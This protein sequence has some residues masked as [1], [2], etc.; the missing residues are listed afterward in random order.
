MR[1]G[2][3]E[4]VGQDLIKS[5][6]ISRR[7]QPLLRLDPHVQPDAGFPQ[8]RAEADQHV[9]RRL[10]GLEPL[11]QLARL[12]GGD[13][14]EAAHELLGA[15]Q[16][17]QQDGRRL[18]AFGQEPLELGPLHLPGGVQLPQ[19]LGALGE[20]ARR[21]DADADRRVDLMGDAG[22]E[23]AERGHLF[24]LHEL[25]LR[26]F[27]P[28]HRLLQLRRP[29]PHPLLQRLAPLVL[30]PVHRQQPLRQLLGL[31]ER[32]GVLAGEQDRLEE[33][34]RQE[35][36]RSERGRPRQVRHVEEVVDDRSGEDGEAAKEQQRPR[37]PRAT[38]TAIAP[39][40]YAMTK[41]A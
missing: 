10:L 14:L 31:G 7:L 25:P 38:A 36:E 34:E 21:G 35:A 24:G 12:A 33:R 6:Y 4:Q 1:D 22:D 20:M 41:Q 26:R 32:A 17:R 8:Q 37:S 18:R 29:L 11:G 28:L 40:P 15:L 13:L 23:T 9:E 30:E 2:V 3:D 5:P 19:P 27:Q 16:V 39:A